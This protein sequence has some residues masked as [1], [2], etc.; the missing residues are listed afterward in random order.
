MPEDVEALR[1]NFLKLFASIPSPLRNEIVAVIDD[2]PYA[3]SAAYLE[4]SNNTLKGDKILAFL[5]HAKIIE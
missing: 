5:K 2:E 1:S 3:W 4:I